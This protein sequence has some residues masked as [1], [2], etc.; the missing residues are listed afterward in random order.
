[1]YRIIVPAVPDGVLKHQV[2]RDIPRDI[3]DDIL[4]CY[5]KLH[6]PGMQETTEIDKA[7]IGKPGGEGD[8]RCH[9]EIR[10]RLHVSQ[11]GIDIE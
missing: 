10:I 1:M 11:P 2:K 5:L 6:G 9:G 7:E 4:L 8:K 3:P